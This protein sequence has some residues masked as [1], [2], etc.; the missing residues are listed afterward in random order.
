MPNPRLARLAAH[1]ARLASFLGAACVPHAVLG[2]QE[3]PASAPDAAPASRSAA[4]HR[5]A[6]QASD[7][8]GRP[9]AGVRL[10]WY[11][12]PPTVF[13]REPR[14]HTLVTGPDGRF[15]I[16]VPADPL[17]PRILRVT[18]AEPG[19]WCLAG[20]V[21]LDPVRGPSG[22]LN[23]I[24]HPCEARVRI[25]VVDPQGASVPGAT[26][27]LGELRFADEDGDGVVEL[28][29]PARDVFAADL[30]APGKAP[31][32]VQVCSGPPGSVAQPR[33][34]LRAAF[35]IRGRV[36]DP[37]GTPLAGARVAHRFQRELDVRTAADGSFDL[38]GI[39][40]EERGNELEVRAEGRQIHRRAVPSGATGPLDLVLRPGATVHGSVLDPQGRP[41]A[42]VLVSA[43][44]GEFGA[45]EAET[46]SDAQGRFVLRGTS[47][48]QLRLLAE[49]PGLTSAT[50][51]VQVVPGLAGEVRLQLL[52]PTRI[53]GRVV[54][55]DGTPV[56]GAGVLL[57]ERTGLAAEP[58]L[59]TTDREGRFHFAAASRLGSLLV[60]QA[61]GRA[62]LGFEPADL[63][64]L[65]LPPRTC[66]AFTV[67]DPDGKPCTEPLRI[68]LGGERPGH[69]RPEETVAT[70]DGVVWLPQHGK[71]SR[72]AIHVTARG[73]R[74]IALGTARPGTQPDPG[75]CVLRLETRRTVR[76]TVADA[77]TGT[78]VAGAR[79]GVL[80][81]R[82][83]GILTHLQPPDVRTDREGRFAVAGL[84][85]G[86]WYVRAAADGSAPQRVRVA[87]GEARDPEPVRVLLEPEVRLVGTVAA[88]ASFGTDVLAVQVSRYGGRNEEEA[89]RVTPDATGA[90]DVGGQVRGDLEVRLLAGTEAPWTALALWLRADRAGVHAVELAPPRGLGVV[91][92]TLVG[93]PPP[94]ELVIVTAVPLRLPSKD[95]IAGVPHLLEVAVP[96]RGGR[97]RI[98]GLAPGNY[99]C[100]ARIAGSLARGDR[101]TVEVPEGA[102][103]PATVELAAP[104]Y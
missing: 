10:Q 95:A 82:T 63:P 3:S 98:E 53:E 5:V 28:P 60:V 66:V 7:E 56:P 80:P 18:S 27:A 11:A 20:D 104:R 22:T 12:E 67:L 50:L 26:V 79:V 16:E 71:E 91:E 59:A 57:H 21:L 45:P 30:R 15:T 17:V 40:G 78:P 94:G 65:R 62:V 8:Q 52:A 19:W 86:P 54:G 37:T 70:A 72:A 93:D 103:R 44:P 49:T 92:G 31:R 33:H 89:V 84:D 6:G 85:A 76:G 51:D 77:A 102:S 38:E 46:F 58:L 32:R 43:R 87:V 55:T 64:E 42:G 25:H 4:A 73:A 74:G 48:G 90:F 75:A 83:R 1:C 61:P 14:T 29:C 81:V 101:V 100:T 96:V 35:R 23:A 9:R 2:A 34:V 24:L 47:S 13:W 69:H 36:V 97:F 39:D 68:D 41:R 88:P 99:R